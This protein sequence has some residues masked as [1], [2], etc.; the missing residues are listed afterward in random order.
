MVFSGKNVELSER[1]SISKYIDPGIHEIMI[2]S[3]EIMEASTGSKRVKF[4]VEGAPVNDPK[5]EGIDGAKGPVGRV[6][7][8]YLK[9][10]EQQLEF[11]KDMKSIASKIG[12]EDAFNEIEAPNFDEYLTKFVNSGVLCGKFF[13][14][15]ITGEEYKNDGKSRWNLSYARYKHCESI[16]IPIESS[17]LKWIPKYHEKRMD[18][19]P[20][21]SLMEGPKVSETKKT[22]DLPF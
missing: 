19:T 3:M 11:I 13:R 16:S 8:S 17:R 6:K 4:N 22:D 18:S 20:I 2:V 21:S 5:F 1:S 14:W 12:A 7:S 10:E 15:I 9:T